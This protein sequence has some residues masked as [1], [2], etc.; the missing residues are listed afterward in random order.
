MRHIRTYQN[1]PLEE[2]TDIVLDRTASNHLCNVLRL[3]VGHQLSVFNGDGHDYA[4]QVIVADKR[5]T[6]L[7]I[8]HATTVS[9]ESPLQIHL[10][11]GISRGDRMDYAIQKAVELGVT[12]IT[13]IITEHCSVKQKVFESK[14]EHWQKIIISACEQ[15][16]R[17][18]IPSLQLPTSLSDWLKNLPVATKFVLSP[19]AKTRLQNINSVADTIA[20]LIGPEGGL[21]PTEVKHCIEHD[22]IDVQLGP[23]ILRTETA[24]CSTIAIIQA[25]FGDS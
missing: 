13:P 18:R 19:E 20:L 16:G 6:Q 8:N 1:L 17:A 4:A 11:Q 9:N 10:G 2:N 7:H 14:Q 25:L 12:Q 5:A 15:S 23:R 22:F 24:A 3:K 21:N